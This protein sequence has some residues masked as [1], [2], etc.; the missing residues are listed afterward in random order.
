[1]RLF[2][3]NL[4]TCNVKA[5]VATAS[6]NPS[7]INNFPLQI[8]PDEGGLKQEESEFR[9]EATARLFRKLDW[10][11]LREAAASL[12]VAELP[13]SPPSNPETDLGFLKSVHDLIMDIHIVEGRL[14]CPNCARAFPIKNGIPNM[15]LTDDEI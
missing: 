14:V 5:C 12:G 15:L 9:P 3:H 2:T 11:A 4:L 10:A 8:I 7:S 13:L 6:R 1:M